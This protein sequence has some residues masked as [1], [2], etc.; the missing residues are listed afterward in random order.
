MYSIIKIIFNCFQL[1]GELH[2]VR[3]ENMDLK[4]RLESCEDT[5]CN[6]SS[7]QLEVDKLKGT[8]LENYKPRELPE[9]APLE[10]PDFDFSDFSQL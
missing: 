4:K 2:E 7:F 8:F 5:S 9:L 3:Q 10:T 1:L 6:S